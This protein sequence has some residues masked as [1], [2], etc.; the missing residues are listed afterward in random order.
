MLLGVGPSAVAASGT[1]DTDD[2]SRLKDTLRIENVTIP[3]SFPLNHAKCG[4]IPAAVGEI[5]PDDN[6]S[7]RTR[8]ITREVR[9]DGSQVIVQDDLIKGR[10]SSYPNNDIYHFVY[11]NHVVIKVSSDLP[12]IVR[13]R[14]IDSFRLKK[15]DDIIMTVGFDWRWRYP[16][17]DP[18]TTLDLGGDGMNSNFPITPVVFPTDDGVTDWEQ[19]STQGDPFNCDPL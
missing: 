7:D 8:E 9:A 16:D 5:K 10:A 2:I 4:A 12:A 1:H 6:R 14:M 13:V 18:G 11:K 15:G 3:W 17:P 19:L